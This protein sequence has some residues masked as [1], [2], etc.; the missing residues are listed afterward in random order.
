MNRYNRSAFQHS[1][2][3]SFSQNPRKNNNFGGRGRQSLVDNDGA[4]N[5]KSNNRN[6]PTQQQSPV[7]Q[8]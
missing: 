6:I 7:Y 8:R 5:N 4:K 3:S 1:Q 2:P